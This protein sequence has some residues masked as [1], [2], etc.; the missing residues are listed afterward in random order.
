MLL[1]P[2][3]QMPILQDMKAITELFSVFVVVSQMVCVMNELQYVQDLMYILL[4]LV[5]EQQQQQQM[6]K[7]SQSHWL[8]V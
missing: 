2:K 3:S 1:K 6:L 5:A 4:G 8:K 7:L